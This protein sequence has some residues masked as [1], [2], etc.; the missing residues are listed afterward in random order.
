MH[1]PIAPL[2]DVLGEEV[3]NHGLPPAQKEQLAGVHDV[4][5]IKD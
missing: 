3:Q 1:L 2:I 4:A 5:K